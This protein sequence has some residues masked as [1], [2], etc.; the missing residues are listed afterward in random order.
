MVNNNRTRPHVSLHEQY[1]EIM[2]DVPHEVPGIFHP[3]NLE[4]GG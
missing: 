4:L 2:L 1:L 3:A